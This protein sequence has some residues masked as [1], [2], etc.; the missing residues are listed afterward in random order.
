MEFKKMLQNPNAQEMDPSIFASDKQ[1]Q[2]RRKAP[3]DD[4]GA[5]PLTVFCAGCAWTCFRQQSSLWLIIARSLLSIAWNGF[6]SGE[7]TYF[8]PAAPHLI[9]FVIPSRQPCSLQTG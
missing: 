4:C 9:C 1:N 7:L 5:P 8:P 6:G 2:K 3:D